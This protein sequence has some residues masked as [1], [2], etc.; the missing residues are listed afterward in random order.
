VFLCKICIIKIKA[1]EN[2][3]YSFWNYIFLKFTY[4]K[5]LSD[6]WRIRSVPIFW[7]S[8]KI[9]L[10]TSRLGNISSM[11]EDWELNRIYLLFSIGLSVPFVFQ[12]VVTDNAESSIIFCFLQ[13]IFL[14]W[15]LRLE[16]I[17]NFYSCLC[18]I[19]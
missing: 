19:G 12:V 4:Y 13:H 11:F 9:F 17:V 14:K 6:L 5:F 3:A 10:K 15:Q 1:S 2:N 16:N 18:A 7:T 8:L